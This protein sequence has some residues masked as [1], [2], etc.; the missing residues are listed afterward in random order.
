MV[1][2][3]AWKKSY[4]IQPLSIIKAIDYRSNKASFV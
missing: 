2:Q 3:S 1:D 4:G